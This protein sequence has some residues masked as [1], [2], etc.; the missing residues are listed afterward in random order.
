[1]LVARVRDRWVSRTE[2]QRRYSE[3]REPCDIRPAE[4]GL[5]FS[6]HSTDEFRRRWPV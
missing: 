6:T 5:R 2:V 4:L 1:M 3:G